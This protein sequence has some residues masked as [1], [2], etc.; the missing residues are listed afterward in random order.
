MAHRLRLVS[1]I[2]VSFLT[3]VGLALGQG[4]SASTTGFGFS[5][6]LAPGSYQ[7]MGTVPALLGQTNARTSGQFRH[8][9]R[10]PESG[11]YGRR[12]HYPQ[13]RDGDQYGSYGYS[14]PYLAFWGPGYSY[15]SY[16]GGAY[17]D[18]YN[19]VDAPL[20]QGGAQQYGAQSQN[21]GGGQNQ[22]MNGNQGQGQSQGQ[23]QQGQGKEQAPPPKPQYL[24]YTPKKES[25]QQKA[26]SG[27]ASPV[28][29]KS[30]PSGSRVTVD[31]YFVGHTPTTV[32]IPYGKHLVSI[33]K[34]GY[35]SS[36]KEI[37]VTAKK[38]VSVNLKLHKDW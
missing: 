18:A 6:G 7:S 19:Y 29:F 31:G 33:S 34:W 1:I 35:E 17:E 21:Q 14:S 15:S 37:D 32:Q 8:S 25:L 36:E 26:K 22:G 23:G 28:D 12:G 20:A 16:Y 38:S 24:T 4:Q 13:R 9:G 30:D 5:G 3:T 27:K 11:W 2:V 10:L